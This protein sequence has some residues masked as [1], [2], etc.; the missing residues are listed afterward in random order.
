M[1][2][3]GL[4][5]Q[6]SEWE[7]ICTEVR[8]ST[9]WKGAEGVYSM[10]NVV[11]LVTP[12]FHTTHFLS[13]GN[14]VLWRGHGKIHHYTALTIYLVLFSDF[15][16]IF[17][18]AVLENLRS[19][20]TYWIKVRYLFIFRLQCFCLYRRNAAAADNIWSLLYKLWFLPH[21]ISYTLVHSKRIKKTIRSF[22]LYIYIY[23]PVEILRIALF[24]ILF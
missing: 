24:T 6:Q 16:L 1:L 13:Y 14:I 8:E 17:L 10:R 11:V 22:L 5:S 15:Y 4:N 9:R 21:A 19:E 3:S 2:R 12:L 7:N 23:I 18:Q 20:A